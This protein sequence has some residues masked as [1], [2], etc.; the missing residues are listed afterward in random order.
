MESFI[1]ELLKDYNAPDVPG[2]A[3]MVIQDGQVGFCK[4][5]GLANRE[6][7]APITDTT[8]FRLAS[9]TKQ[10]TAMAVLILKERG[11]LNLDDP[12]AKFLA[13]LPEWG[14]KITLRNLLTHT[15][16]LVAYENILLLP[17]SKP[18]KDAQVLELLR[19]QH[20]TYFTPGSNARYSNSGYAL[21][22]L[23]VAQVSGQSFATFL[24]KNIFTPL[25]MNNSVVF[26]E[27]I[28]DVENRAY[29]YC[30]SEEGFT[31]CDQSDTSA[32]LGDGGIY[33]SVSDLFHWDQALY[34]EQ[35]VSLQTIQE[36]FTAQNLS[37]GTATAY[38]FGWKISNCEGI[39]I[40]GHDGSSCGFRNAIRRAPEKKVTVI[41][42]TN[43][44]ETDAASITNTL[45][46]HILTTPT[47][48]AEQGKNLTRISHQANC[49]NRA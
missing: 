6:N 28:S 16:G 33:S 46:K 12:V 23:V 7:N 38:G 47:R 14:D 13:P 31:L 24:N 4:T 35:L 44:K 34:S 17:H 48:S 32:V 3:L 26:E 1:D 49:C 37:G 11:Q 18:L 27:G 41:L 21:L 43:R 5:Y 25:G 29:G 45:M 39:K 40:V 22:A 19:T 42:L 30:K 36:A 15:S 8:N 10:F 9:V 2:G 20:G